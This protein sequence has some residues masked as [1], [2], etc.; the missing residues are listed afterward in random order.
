LPPT[1]APVPA[2]YCFLN[3]AKA[4][5]N[6]HG[7]SFRAAH[8][9]HGANE[10]LRRSL[11]GETVHFHKDGVL[12]GLCRLL[13]EDTKRTTYTLK[14]A[15][16][17]LPYIHRAYSLTF[18]SLPEQFIPIKN[19]RFVRKT[20]SKEAWFCA[21]VE[22]RYKNKFTARKLPSGWEFDAGSRNPGTIRMTSRFRWEGRRGST[23]GN[24]DRLRTYHRKVR[25]HICYIYGPNRL[26]YL[27]R[28]EVGRQWL[29]RSSLTLTFAAMHRLSELSRYEPLSLRGHLDRQHNW[30]LSESIA[31]SPRQ[32]IDEVAAEITGCDFMAPGIRK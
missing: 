6:V 20:Q 23:K 10:P 32:F 2:Y 5:L 17:N 28:R 22:K 9:V 15:L 3:A 25:R 19:P 4:L 7:E 14:Q 18:T 1:S 29:N 11:E 31:V 12:A 8:G 30:L 24:R 13:G 26:W 21:E 16:Y 27:K